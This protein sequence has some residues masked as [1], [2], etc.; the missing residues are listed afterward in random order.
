MRFI[1]RTIKYL[2]RSVFSIII[3][4]LLVGLA[5]TNRDIDAYVMS[6]NTTDWAE[7]HWAQP[8]TWVAPFWTNDYVSGDISD[9]F[10][11]DV[12]DT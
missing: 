5:K 3:F 4:L 12:I 11:D 10:S 7:L 9:M 1:G 2:L 8:D 6:L